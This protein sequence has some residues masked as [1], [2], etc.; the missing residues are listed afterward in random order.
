ML[1]RPGGEGVARSGARPRGGVVSPA[2]GAPVS[3][4]ARRVSLGGGVRGDHP[5]LLGNPV[6]DLG[7]Q[8]WPDAGCKPDEPSAIRFSRAACRVAGAAGAAPVQHEREGQAG[9][10]GRARAGM[11]R[12]SGLGPESGSLLS[13]SLIAVA[14]SSGTPPPVPTARDRVD[15]GSQRG[16]PGVDVLGED[17]HPGSDHR[18]GPPAARTRK[19]GSCCPTTRRSISCPASDPGRDCGR[20]RARARRPVNRARALARG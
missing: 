14:P 12:V 19:P 13:G 18:R 10:R 5:G 16:V 1:V 11:I 20:S 2:P 15:A 17:R 7:R 9:G 4:V 8:T 3:R 6:E